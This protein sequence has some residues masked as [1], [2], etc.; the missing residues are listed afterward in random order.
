M[1]RSAWP[2]RSLRERGGTICGQPVVRKGSDEAMLEVSAR[3]IDKDR[4]ERMRR[5][6]LRVSRMQIVVFPCSLPSCRNFA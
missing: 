3:P 6:L 5:R 1:G 2:G 4:S